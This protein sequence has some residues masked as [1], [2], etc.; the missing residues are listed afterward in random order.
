M[1]MRNITNIL[2]QKT[3][4]HNGEPKEEFLVS[5]S[6]DP[7]F[8][9]RYSNGRH[10]CFLVGRGNRALLSIPLL[11]TE[12]KYF[13]SDY[14]NYDYLPEEDEAIHRSVSSFVPKARR[15]PATPS[16]AYT[17][18]R[19]LFLPEF[20]EREDTPMFYVSYRKSPSYIEFSEDTDLSSEDFLSY[21][22]SVFDALT[23]S[24]FA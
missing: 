17:K 19:G 10:S 4:D 15:R 5:L 18:K 7:P 16:T 2:R 22:S 13:F 20:R 9:E 23:E 8:P 21:V 11:S 6:V 3:T 12:L 24:Y 14:K 1:K